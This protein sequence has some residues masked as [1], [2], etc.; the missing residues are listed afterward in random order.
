MKIEKSNQQAVGVASA[1]GAYALWGIMPIYWKLV[2]SVPSLEI[3]AHR[4]VWSLVFLFFVLLAAGK[5]RSF[6]AE[7]KAVLANPR[8][9]LCLASASI[10]V[11]VNWLTFIWAVTHEHIIET[12][13]GYYINPL[14]SV[15]LGIAVLKE[16]LSFWQTVSF[17]L[18]AIGVLN[19]TLHFGAFPW[20]A[21]ILAVSFGLYG[22]LKK[23]LNFG[24]LSGI[25][26]ETLIIF[27]L[28]LVYLAY[29]NRTGHGAFTAGPPA[30][31][32][33]LAGAGIVTA[34]PLILFAS[35]A[36]RLPLS[37]VG[38]LQYI[39]PTISLVLGV[40]LYHE[41]FT[42]VHLVSFVLI[43]AALTI[44]SLSRTRS[45]LQLESSVQKKLALKGR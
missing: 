3:L 41:P 45:L 7:L 5:L 15:F 6:S 8:Q 34:V 14:I 17:F 39:S 21:L 37:T 32:L 36:I 24:A 28:P 10:I 35:G 44:F 4:I 22:L 2:N 16:K 27:P 40:F 25:A 33:L 23:V 31:T 19:L 30:V 29:L 1:A 9:R 43:W 42:A 20:V 13:L 11:S 12:S 26:A 38:F 18:A